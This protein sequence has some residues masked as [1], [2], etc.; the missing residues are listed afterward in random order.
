VD[1]FIDFVV[2][3]GDVPP[4]KSYPDLFGYASVG[5][6]VGFGPG[7]TALGRRGCRVSGFGLCR[8]DDGHRPIAAEG[9]GCTCRVR[10]L[11]RTAPVNCHEIPPGE[12]FAPRPI[13]R[14]EY[15][16]SP[17]EYPGT[18]LAPFVP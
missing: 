14:S 10:L 9:T 7:V 18:L 15:A 8:S 12:F 2:E 11:R 13:W 1:A 4:T 16:A 3:G 5:L 6:R 17:L